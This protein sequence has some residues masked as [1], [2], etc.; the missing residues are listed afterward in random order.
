VSDVGT[1]IFYF[2]V[3]AGKRLIV[4]TVSA[5]AF[6]PPGV[7]VGAEVGINQIPS[8]DEYEI[9]MHSNGVFDAGEWF[10]GT[11]PLKLRVDSLA[12]NPSASIYVR[13]STSNLNGG[14]TVT[15]SVSGYLVDL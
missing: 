4:E 9:P 14:G 8:P 1:E 5:R 11:Q 13:V 3:P 7:K 6:V 15:A 12:V 10:A 2:P